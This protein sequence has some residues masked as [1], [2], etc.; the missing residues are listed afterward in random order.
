CVLARN[1][2]DFLVSTYTQADIQQII[3]KEIVAKLEQMT[4]TKEF[5]D[6]VINVLSTP[7]DNMCE[8]FRMTISPIKTDFEKLDSTIKDYYIFNWDSF[9]TVYDD[10]KA[11]CELR[12]RIDKLSSAYIRND[13]N[14]LN[15]IK[16]TFDALNTKARVYF[17]STYEKTLNELLDSLKIINVQNANR[18]K[19]LIDKIAV[20]TVDSGRK[21]VEAEQAYAALTENEKKMVDNYPVLQKARSEYDSLRR[22]ISYAFVTGMKNKFTY[23]GTAIKPVPTVTV[24]D[25]VLVKGTDFILKYKSNKDVG[26]AH[27]TIS[28]VDGGKYIGEK[29]VAFSIV[30]KSIS[31][32]AVSGVKAKYNYS[33]K[34]K[35][36]SFTLKVDGRKLK[37]G[38][39]YT[40]KYSN[41]KKRGKATIIITGKGNYKGTK[42]KTFKIV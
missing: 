29:T 19:E 23:T 34:R 15:Q 30:K 22:D 17:G 5:L 32:G 39:D 37:K 35:K 13:E 11:A 14:E 33:G 28:A 16:K 27:L 41:N 18:V 26:K 20:V 7:D 24:D 21:I 3:T 4:A 12:E 6:R 8:K 38:T 42:K 2:Y 40:V 1:E 36:P 25:V 9:L 10:T 31:G